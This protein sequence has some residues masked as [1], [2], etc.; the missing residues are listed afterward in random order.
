MVEVVCSCRVQL[1]NIKENE[2]LEDIGVD[3]GII[4]K[5]MG[6]CGLNSFRAG[7]NG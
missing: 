1:G 4:L 2:N 7:I 5:S 3:W 6:M